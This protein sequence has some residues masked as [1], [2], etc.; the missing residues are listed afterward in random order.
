MTKPHNETGAFR[1]FCHAQDDLVARLSHGAIKTGALA[2]AFNRHVHDLTAA[3]LSERE[4][5]AAFWDAVHTVRHQ[6]PE[7]AP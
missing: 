5:A 3:G 7:V 1:A 4:A 6:M 2:A